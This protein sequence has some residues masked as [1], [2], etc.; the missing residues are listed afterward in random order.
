MKWAGDIKPDDPLAT[1][2]RLKNVTVTT[3]PFG[4][5]EFPKPL[6]VAW[7][8][9]NY[10]DLKIAKFG[11]VDTEAFDR[12]VFAALKPGGS[13]FILDHAGPAGTDLAGIAR[14][15]RIDKA[16]VIREV[17]AAGFKLAEEGTFLHRAADDHTLSIYDKS[18]QGKTDQ[19]ALRFVKPR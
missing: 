16:Q 7:V 4:T 15:H 8:T 12:A 17:T 9:Q 6:D 11:V 3:G 1:G 13:F 14:L 18:V 5:V 10:H 19:F 2:G